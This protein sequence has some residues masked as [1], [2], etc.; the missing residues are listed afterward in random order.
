MTRLAIGL[1]ALSSAAV[2]DVAFD[3]FEPGNSYTGFA[4]GCP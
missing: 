3:N 4:A 2:A 1:L